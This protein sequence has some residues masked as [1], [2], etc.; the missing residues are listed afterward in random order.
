MGREWRQQ[1]ADNGTRLSRKHPRGLP[2]GGFLLAS[3]LGI[4][5]AGA[6]G[7]ICFNLHANGG[8]LRPGTFEDRHIDWIVGLKVC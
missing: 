7:W 8:Y 1:A 5:E 6:Y 3:D 2:T 4:G